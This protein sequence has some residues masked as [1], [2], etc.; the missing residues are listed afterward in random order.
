MSR[1]QKIR[2]RF[3]EKWRKF[4]WASGA[5]RGTPSAIERHRKHLE[6]TFSELNGLMAGMHYQ[7]QTE[8]STTPVASSSP[9][10]TAHNYPLEIFDDLLGHTPASD[11]VASSEPAIAVE[12]EPMASQW[13]AIRSLRKETEFHHRRFQVLAGRLENPIISNLL[14][15]YPDARS[16]RNK[17]AC[18]VK[19]VL[20][21]FQPSKL[22]IVFAFTC[23]SYSISQLLYKKKA[24]DKSD[25]LADIRAW[26]DLIT[27]PNE[28]QAFN[29]LAP[30]LWPEAKEHLHFIDI[31]THPTNGSSRWANHWPHF[32]PLA[33]PAE[34][35]ASQFSRPHPNGQTTVG[36]TNDLHQF[37]QP[38]D[39]G[40][41]QPS[42]PGDDISF[43]DQEVQPTELDHSSGGREGAESDI[44]PPE[45]ATLEN[46]IMFLV[47]LVF[48]RDL[49]EWYLY[50]LSGRSLAPK[51]HKLYQT[52]QGDQ[53]A[54]RRKAQKA[55]FEPCSRH[56]SSSHSAF[57]ALVSVAEMFTRNGYLQSIAEIKQY[58]ISVASAV[59]LPG[60]AYEQIVS[61]VLTISDDAPVAPTQAT[62]A[63]KPQKR[64]RPVDEDASPPETGPRPTK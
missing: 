45:H 44:Q 10:Q 12:S 57:R 18:I 52:E 42:A 11:T 7:D 36:G 6:V 26:R 64:P 47:V 27:D 41:S 55:F 43:E 46:T 1:A 17:G 54:F 2:Q 14:E 31:P 9:T 63:T 21:G 13:A 34:C 8:G 59:L 19:D 48:L 4:S 3:Q 39:T 61:S 51:R 62:Q 56:R 22:S 37:Q 33:D 23:F 29:H 60:A 15:T 28:R 20:E 5:T 32:T 38:P 35:S 58:V 50:T 53:E 16:I 40:W 24:I 25:I 30:E 49:G